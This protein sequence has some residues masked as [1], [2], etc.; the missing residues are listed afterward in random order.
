MK[1]KKIAALGLCLAMALTSLPLGGMELKAD[2]IKT[3][4]TIQKD[5]IDKNNLVDAINTDSYMANGYDYNTPITKQ[6]D[7]LLKATP[8]DAAYGNINEII[9][10]YPATRN[11]EP[12]G[13]CWA[14]SAV[15]LAEFDMIK[16]GYVGND[17][18]YS[19]LQLAYFTYHRVADPLGGTSGDYNTLV[20]EPGVQSYL[21]EGG[22]QYYAMRS[23]S[24]WMGVVNESLVPYSLAQSTVYGSLPSEYAYSSNQAILLNV[25]LANIHQQSYIVKQGIINHGAAAISYFAHDS[26]YSTGYYNGIP[27][28]TYYY[29]GRGGY[30]A[31]H[32]VTV[33]GWDDNF[34]ASA[35]ATNP[36]GNG[37]WL[38]RNS[39]TTETGYSMLSYFW[40][41]YY[42]KGLADT[43]YIMDFEPANKYDN[44]YQYDGG[45]AIGILNPRV[46]SAANI[47]ETKKSKYGETLEAVQLSFTNYADV[48]YQVQIVTGLKNANNPMS[49]KVVAKK[50]GTT[51][52]AGIYTVKLNKPVYLEPGEKFAVVVTQTN[53]AFDIEID[54]DMTQ[55]FGYGYV[56][57]VSP[58]GKSFAYS[59]SM[60]IN[61]S[62]FKANGF[63]YGDICLRAITKDCKT[64]TVKKTS[65]SSIKNTSKGVKISWKKIDI[66]SSYTIQRSSNKR[67]WKSIKTSSKTSYTDTSVK[68]NIGKK[69][70]YR[71]LVNKKNAS[72]VKSITR[73]SA[74]TG[75]TLKNVSKKK[76][77]V[78]Y[79][80]NKKVT[81]Y[82]IQ[83]S[84][85]KNFK[86]SVKTVKLKSNKTTKKLFKGLKKGK[87]YYVRVR[88]Y[89]NGS[90]SGWSTV[91]KIKIKK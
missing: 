24:G 89:K 69:Y 3:A 14:F 37:A 51:S 85:K 64:K 27:V 74:P 30:I 76:L 9:A 56:S 86:S 77:L 6:S 61:C 46:A 82:Q 13:T 22:N 17:V 10:T 47:Y 78:T 87:V 80:R 12:Y 55:S 54:Y 50:S 79:K 11:Q 59:N 48:H 19:A 49:G 40:L 62:E 70:Y 29:D 71:V 52:N 60:W 7:G 25:K 18:N 16:Q 23:L 72:A 66:A 34:P 8:Y 45:F 15:S 28:P 36:M 63:E 41:S 21:Y 90:Y 65:I 1:I 91:K 67:N 73:V 42:D 57:H 2:T 88:A 31:N 68:K 84:T 44:L 53:G 75:V 39:W 43:A 20:C 33:V 35:F 83:Y 26:L 81:G 32:A 38:V 5:S 58:S 4:D